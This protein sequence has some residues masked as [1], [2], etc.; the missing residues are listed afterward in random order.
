MV[1]TAH[2][3]A[4]GIDLKNDTSAPA[5]AKYTTDEN[6]TTPV[7]V[8]F[9]LTDSTFVFRFK[10]SNNKPVSEFFFFFVSF[11]LY[12]EKK[13]FF[14]IINQL[15]FILYIFIYVHTIYLYTYVYVCI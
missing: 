12:L 14:K 7:T 4:S 10:F 13:K 2:Q 15:M 11:V 5:S 1:T 9:F 6:S 3:N 8:F